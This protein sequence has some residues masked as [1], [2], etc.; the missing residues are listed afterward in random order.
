MR[1]PSDN[2]FAEPRVIA[3]L[4]VTAVPRQPTRGNRPA[5]S[6]TVARIFVVGLLCSVSLWGGAAFAQMP[7]DCVPY[8]T[9][10][11]GGFISDTWTAMNPEDFFA[12]GMTIPSDPGGGYAT[13]QL[14]TGLGT[15]NPTRPIPALQLDN[16]PDAGGGV[17]LG[18]SAAQSAN[19]LER[20]YVFEVAA[21]ESYSFHAFAFFD[22]PFYPWPYTISWSFFSRMDC[23]EPNNFREDAK[24][25]PLSLP[26]EAY[27][28]SGY[29]KSFISDDR[30]YDW[31]KFTLDESTE[32]IIETLQVPSDQEINFRLINEAG[33][34][35]LSEFPTNPGELISIGPTTLPADTW[36]LEVEADTYG[37]TALDVH[38]S[39]PELPDHFNTPYRLWV[40]RTDDVLFRDNF[41]TGDSG[42]WSSTTP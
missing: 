36:Y 31:Y 7:H 37:V 32:V 22:P 42:N 24:A 29:T 26:I 8:M 19:E 11:A 25:I 20:L 30:N 21:G 18:G 27:G 34:L 15:S 28:I 2:V 13:V 39:G 14:T 5:W 40:L 10:G 41:E 17:I 9:T 4:R 33:Q 1:K 35:W 12:P 3:V 16:F 6:P 23:Y 38:F